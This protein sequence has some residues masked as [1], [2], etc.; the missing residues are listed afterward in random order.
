MG[1]GQVSAR[2]FTPSQDILGVLLSTIVAGGGLAAYQTVTKWRR[3]RR[4]ERELL[5]TKQ[6]LNA[7]QDELHDTK[8]LLKTK[9]QDLKLLTVQLEEAK[10]EIGTRISEHMIISRELKRAHKQLEDAQR[11]LQRSQSELRAKQ[12][13]DSWGDDSYA[14]P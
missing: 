12:M 11:Q 4:R 14:S 9:I 2:H 7:T 1:L 10:G 6:E 8:A 13:N 3:F 5:Q